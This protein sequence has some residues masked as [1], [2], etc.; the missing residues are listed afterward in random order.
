MGKVDIE[1]SAECSQSSICRIKQG[2][3]C[4]IIEKAR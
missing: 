2:K 4:G 3:L 1:F